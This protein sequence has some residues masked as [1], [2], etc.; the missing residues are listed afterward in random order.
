MHRTLARS[1]LVAALALASIAAGCRR[2]TPSTESPSERLRHAR[3]AALR[4]ID[5]PVAQSSSTPALRPHLRVV[6]TATGIDLDSTELPGVTL[7]SLRTNVVSLSNGAFRP[8]D[9]RGGEHG[10]L[11][12]PLTD[13][14][15]AHTSTLTRGAAER[16]ALPIAVY[17]PRSTTEDTLYRTLYTIAQAGFSTVFFAMR[18]SDEVVGVQ[19]P[20]R[21]A[22]SLRERRTSDCVELSVKIRSDAINVQAQ[23]VRA[24]EL[25]NAEERVRRTILLP[26]ERASDA[27][28]EPEPAPPSST[29]VANASGGF[30]R[31]AL[32]AAM[33]AMS[34]DAGAPTCRAPAIVASRQITHEQTMAIRE[35]IEFDLRM[36]APEMG[37]LN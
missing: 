15:L 25:A 32:A 13:A 1:A 2:N 24:G 34:A 11:V 4:A 22:T 14:L 3:T 23:L 33:R 8:E 17:A 6:F 20:L 16:A 7:S 31:A 5:L 12:T 37:M 26:Y 9:L 19:V 27:G 36:G 30:D 35:L 21:S 18:G 10:F 29:T 28:A